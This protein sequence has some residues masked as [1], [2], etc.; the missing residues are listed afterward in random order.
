MLLQD[1]MRRR[2]TLTGAERSIADYM[3]VQREKVAHISARQIAREVYAAPSTVVRFCQKFGY[4]GYDDFREAFLVELHYLTSHFTS[5][6]PNVPFGFGERRGVIAHKMGTLYREVVDDTL[7]LLTEE[8]LDRAVAALDAADEIC[9]FSTG[10]QADIAQGFRDKML[11]IG[12]LTTIEAR[13]NAAFYRAAHADPARS[14]FIIMS[15]SGE[16][17]QLLRVARKLNERA[18]PLIAITSFGGNSLSELADIVLCVSTR[19]KLER[20]IGHFAMNVSTMLLLDTLYACIFNENRYVNFESRV[21]MRQQFE[22]W[23]T[24]S[25]PLLA[26]EPTTPSAEAAWELRRTDGKPDAPVA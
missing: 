1:L 3:L 9:L 15:Y 26:D 11:K 20:N 12:R 25:N 18:V 23:R 16:T 13:A 22:A 17:E 19:E 14:V 4:A 5:V 2:S 7:G 21:E 10:V 6:D 8:V 24:S